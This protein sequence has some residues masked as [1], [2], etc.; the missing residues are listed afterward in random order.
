MVGGLPARRLLRQLS[1]VPLGSALAAQLPA[2]RFRGRLATTDLAARAWRSVAGP[3]RRDGSADRGRA[4]VR[5]QAAQHSGSR[6][7]RAG[8]PSIRHTRPDRPPAGTPAA[9]RRMVGAGHVRARSRI[10]FRRPAHARRT[11]RRRVPGQRPQDLD[12]P[13]PRVAVVHPVCPHRSGRPETPRHLV[14]HPRYALTRSK[15]RA[16]PDG[17]DLRR[18]V[19][20]GV[21]R[22]R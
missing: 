12:H 22:R 6:R 9:R 3:A 13:G 21:P 5:A 11:R 19:L 14:P 10:G 15:S 18:D 1:A 20:R 2:G 17:V 7:R 16:H 4:A 8:H